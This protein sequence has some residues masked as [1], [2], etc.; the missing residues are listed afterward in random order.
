[1][2]TNLRQIL[3]HERGDDFE[4][5]ILDYDFRIDGTLLLELSLLESLVNSGRKTVQEIDS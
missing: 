3:L 2:F 5:L 1:M 4:G